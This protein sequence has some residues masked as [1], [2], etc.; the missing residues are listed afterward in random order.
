MQRPWYDIIPV[1]TVL[2]HARRLSIGKSVFPSIKSVRLRVRSGRTGILVSVR[3]TARKGL[4]GTAGVLGG[5][6][7]QVTP[8]DRR[9]LWVIDGPYR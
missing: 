5:A 6:I 2:H 7:F 3:T 1:L 9:A 4:A 8:D